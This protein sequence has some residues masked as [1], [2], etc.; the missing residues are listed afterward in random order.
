MSNPQPRPSPAL[1]VAALTRRG[2]AR[3]TTLAAFGFAACLAGMPGQAAADT[4]A[5][6][7]ESG[8]LTLGVRQTSLPFSY[9]PEGQTDAIGYSVDLCMRVAD[10][11]REQLGLERLEVRQV[12]VTP[13]DRMERLEDGTIDLECGST[14]NTR[15]RQQ[16]VA[17]SYTTFVTGVRMAVLRDSGIEQVEDLE[18]KTIVTTKGT[19]TERLLVREN[20]M[21]FL[22]G[23]QLSF[24]EDHA[25][26]FKQVADAKAVAFFMDDILLAGLITRSESPDRYNITGRYLTVEPYALMFRK[27]DAAFADL[28][29]QTLATLMSDGEIQR[30]YARW[31]VTPTLNFPLTRMTREAF[32]YPNTTPA[33]P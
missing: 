26:S 8:V 20:E 11:V 25:E 5:K 7:A 10:A 28:V 3:L 16:R 30:I 31:F 13:S 12:V 2:F 23:T 29:N 6:V 14:T 21:G 22:R 1:S 19:S 32:A 33:F 15:D 17:F 9:V 27:D 4:L 24:A 18:G